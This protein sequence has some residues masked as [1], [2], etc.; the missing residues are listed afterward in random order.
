MFEGL[1]IVLRGL[2]VFGI[3]VLV[4]C[5]VAEIIDLFDIWRNDNA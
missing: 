4:G 5:I 3:P 2:M 1:T